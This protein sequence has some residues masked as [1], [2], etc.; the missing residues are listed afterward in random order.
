MAE[1]SLFASKEK[2]KSPIS[3]L[4]AAPA[5]LLSEGMP[6]PP[7]PR[8]GPLPPILPQPQLPQL[9]ALTIRFVGVGD[10]GNRQGLRLVK[11]N[12]LVMVHHAPA[13]ARLTQRRVKPGPNED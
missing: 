5:A 9:S 7:S 12:I 13:G 3:R 1:A 10:C 2:F 11:D 4:P 6:R 8:K